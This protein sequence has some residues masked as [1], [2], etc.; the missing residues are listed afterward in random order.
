MKTSTNSS[1]NETTASNSKAIAPNNS[2]ESSMNKNGVSISGNTNKSSSS[3]GT[4]TT[5]SNNESVSKIANANTTFKVQIGAFSG[6]PDKSQFAGVKYEV[7]MEEGMTKILTG[8]FKNFDDA[9]KRKDELK[10]KGFDA[11]VVGYEN[12]KRIPIK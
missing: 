10:G 12:G 7:S 5:T 1:T 11:F 2:N 8:S 6:K 4:A 9:I 3:N